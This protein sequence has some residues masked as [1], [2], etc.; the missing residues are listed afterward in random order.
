MLSD[1]AQ[2]LCCES[3]PLLFLCPHAVSSSLSRALCLVFSVHCPQ[4]PVQHWTSFLL[5]ALPL[6]SPQS[7]CREVEVN[8]IYAMYFPKVLSFEEQPPKT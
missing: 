2:A 8:C 6:L 5:E 4:V 3:K 7:P 1:T